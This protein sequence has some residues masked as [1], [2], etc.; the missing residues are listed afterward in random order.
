MKYV[1]SSPGVNIRPASPGLHP[2]LSL[3]QQ[4]L[5]PGQLPGRE[6]GSV[7]HR[8][9]PDCPQV[10]SSAL[11]VLRI[12]TRPIFRETE[13]E[14][15]IPSSSVDVWGQMPALSSS[16]DGEYTA[17]PVVGEVNNYSSLQLSLSTEEVSSVFTVPLTTL[18]DPANHGYT[19]F[20]AGAGR[21]WSLPVYHG[22]GPSRYL[23][24]HS[25]HHRPAAPGSPAQ[26]GLQ[27]Q[28]SLSVTCSFQGEI[29][30]SDRSR[31][32]NSYCNIA[33]TK[34]KV[35]NFNGGLFSSTF[36]FEPI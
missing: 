9:G 10:S 26:L 24:P 17:T 29:N 32:I 25:H 3:P 8:P 28:Y 21:G 1:L 33:A 4:S 16:K 22:G 7:R 14:L 23:G 20:R 35:Q 6:G 2:A 19:Q 27:T 30:L 5:R 36:L 12:K 34:S 11:S 18:I 15:G 31:L 13:E